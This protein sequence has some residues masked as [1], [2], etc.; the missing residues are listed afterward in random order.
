MWENAVVAAVIIICAV[1]VGRRFLRQFKN[2]VNKDGSSTCGGDCS[3][4]SSRK[5]LKK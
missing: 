3:G 1:A 2:S 5:G 4:C